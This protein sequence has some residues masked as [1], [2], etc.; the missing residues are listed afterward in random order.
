[1]FTPI[2][3]TSQQKKTKNKKLH[4]L[5]A[6]PTR[7]MTIHKIRH[8]YKYVYIVKLFY[9]PHG[10]SC[11]NSWPAPILKNIFAPA[12]V[13]PCGIGFADSS[14]LT[15]HYR[16]TSVRIVM[17]DYLRVV[18]S[19][20]WLPSLVPSMLEECFQDRVFVPLWHHQHPRSHWSLQYWFISF[21]S[22][23][24]PQCMEQGEGACYFLWV[25]GKTCSYWLKSPLHPTCML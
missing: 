7:S 12:N 5:W 15:K 16:L 14:T 13:M 22:N 23:F 21:S 3:Q 24:L 1:M 4:Q 10:T 18:T 17:Q 25:W 20:P 2:L 9:L 8:A 19:I 6:E 11:T